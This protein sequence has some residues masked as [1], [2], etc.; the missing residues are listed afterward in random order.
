MNVP[1]ARFDARMRTHFV[2]FTVAGEGTESNP[3]N[4]VFEIGASALDASVLFECV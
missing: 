4:F 2:D 1:K 3:A